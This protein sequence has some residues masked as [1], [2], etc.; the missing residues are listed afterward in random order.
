M[1][2]SMLS[3][4]KL[5]NIISLNLN[6]F[7]CIRNLDG[8]YIF[9]NRVLDDFV[10]LIEQNL[11]EAYFIINSKD[12]L[13]RDEKIFS[14]DDVCARTDMV[15]RSKL[16]PINF[17]L[18]CYING[19]WFYIEATKSP[20]F[21]E[22][23]ELIGVLVNA[24]DIT[25]DKKN[26]QEIKRLSY[27]D[28]LTSLPNRKKIEL[29]IDTKKPSICI[30][31]NI[32]K[33]REINDFFGSSMGDSILQ[34][35][36]NWFSG[37]GNAYRTG[38]D[39]FAL[40]LYEDMSKE[41]VEI[42]VR[43]TL[44]RFM[45][46]TFYIEQEPVPIRLNIGISIKGDKPLTQ[47][48]IAL[49]QAKIKHTQYVFYEEK[50]N[51][52]EI[53]RSNLMIATNIHNA[54][55]QDRL[56]CFYQPIF[57]FATMKITKYETLVRLLC[58]DDSIM[59]PISFLSIA[60][61]TK[62]YTKLTQ[63]VVKKACLEFRDKNE[64]FSINISIDDIQDPITTQYIINTIIETN[65]A[66]RIIFE[67]LESDGIENYDSVER[68]IKQ[69]KAL[70]AKIA[71]DDFGSGYSSFEHILRLDID[72][73]KIDGALIRDITTKK[74]SH[75]VVSTIVDFA[76]KI[77]VETIAEFVGNKDIFEALK[78]MG[79]DFAQGYYIGEPKPL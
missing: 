25:A 16:K 61:K 34:Q 79:I 63:M 62:L 37:I 31:F 38:G 67:I 33:F 1:Q 74:N 20:I 14:F 40:L 54:L 9:T 35:V 11:D 41:E 73:I 30:L 51:I 69:V 15:V 55:K 5:L 17:E 64:E 13:L 59:P 6:D 32:D 75:I 49:H 4:E 39:E 65:T 48:D 45:A 29:D 46:T 66:S 78:S 28:M 53:Y 10:K 60:K 57:D 52:E 21:S 26:R 7:L 77:G 18:S 71:I 70:G 43:D 27:N 12:N 3:S 24:K 47:A 42:F 2:M 68:F 22:N 44:D 76:N 23:A 50:S 72:Y 19:Q 58:V 36:A 8:A 56:I